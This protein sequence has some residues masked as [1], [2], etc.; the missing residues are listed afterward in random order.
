MNWP[1]VHTLINH[2]PIILVVMGA[3]AAVTALVL[4]RRGIWL[5]SV[6]SLTLAGLSIYPAFLS[7]DEASDAL[8]NTWYIVPS[9]VH[10][11]EE[12]AELA[13]WVVIATGVIGLFA[14]WW[15]LRRSDDAEVPK[16]LRVLVV[17]SSL[18]SVAA[19]TYT[20]V[21]GGRI[22]HD[23]PKLTA[24]PPGVVMDTARRG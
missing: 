7:G 21:L 14:W 11:H 6:A 24:P 22:V 1:Y 12:S 13:L 16:W 8:K 17:V 2:F 10:D 4:R 5:Y 15:M 23:S 19:I 3:A 18:A 9:M 20:S